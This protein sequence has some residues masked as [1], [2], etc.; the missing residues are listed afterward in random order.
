MHCDIIIDHKGHEI[1]YQNQSL[2]NIDAVIPRIGSSVTNFGATI[3]RQ[4]ESM[5]VFTTLGSDPL[6]RSRDKLSCLQL[7]SAHGLKVP[8][9]AITNNSYNYRQILHEI[10]PEPHVLKL[11]N[12]THGLG[13]MLSESVS[14]S[15]SILEAF[16]RS[17]QML[18][19]QK[20]IKEAAGSDIR[21]LVVDGKVAAAMK[22]QAL[23]GEFRSNLHRGGMGTNYYLTKDEKKVA[24][25]ATEILGLKVA[26]VDLLQS[27]EGPMILEVNASPGLEG[28]ENVTGS[29]IAGR[30]INY[31]EQEHLKRSYKFR[32]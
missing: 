19:V 32:Q 13:V 18:M 27:D 14:T 8:R 20:F 16:N 10:G 30:I 11:V 9:T 24:L 1:Y 29:D 22:R 3:I 17:D 5:K 28:I 12:G 26:G 6:L 21:V 4:F 2:Q 31:I 23:P 25:R 15:E 7:L